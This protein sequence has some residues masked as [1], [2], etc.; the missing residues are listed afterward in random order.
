MKRRRPALG[1]AAIT[2]VT[3]IAAGCTT[4]PSSPAPVMEHFCDLWSDVEADPTPSEDAVLVD[5]GLVARAE[6]ASTH[7]Q[8]IGRASCRERV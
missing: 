6:T 4:A 5:D 1:V 8:E 2:V 7:G 3:L